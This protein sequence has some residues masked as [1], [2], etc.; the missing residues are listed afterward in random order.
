MLDEKA[1]R[2]FTSA[3]DKAPADNRRLRRLLATKAPWER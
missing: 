3:L 1:F 2:Q